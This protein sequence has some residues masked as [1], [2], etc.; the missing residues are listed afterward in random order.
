MG[1]YSRL[2]RNTA[3]IF[4]GTAGSKLMSL[5]MLPF[6][7]RWLTTADYGSTDLISTYAS[8][9]LGVV[10]FSIFDAIFIFPKNQSE[11]IQKKY[12]SSGM[13]FLFIGLAITALLSCIW[14]W[15]A[16]GIN[17][18][19]FITE[20]LWYI[21]GILGISYIQT[22]CQQ[23]LRAIDYMVVY[24]TTG[25]VTTI[26]TFG[27][28]FLLIPHGGVKGYVMAIICA[29]L[30][31]VIYSIVY[32]KLWRF[33]GVQY[34]SKES[35]TE[36]L[37]Y[38]IPLIPN[39]LMWFLINAL[40]RPVIEDYCGLSSVGL[41]AVAGR[42]PTLLN[43]VYLL[44]QQA[45]LISVL[46]ESSKP[47]YEEYYNRMLKIVVT[48]QIFFAAV[49]AFGGKWII[50]LFTTPDFYSAWKYISI[51]VIGVLFMNI[52]TFVGSNFAVLKKSKYYFY[53]TVWGGIASIVLNF[54]L[55]PFWGLWGACMAIVGSQA[56]V[57]ISRI[58][59]SSEFVKLTDA[60]F[61]IL[62]GIFICVCIICSL[63]LYDS[64]WMYISIILVMCYYC[65]INIRQIRLTKRLI[66]KYY[67]SRF[68][69]K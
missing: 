40:N 49:L 10:S 39:S 41:F 57:M 36:M 32:G 52:G 44:F 3:L 66:N 54:S 1:K 14:T 13:F 18:K 64:W 59:Y 58:K 42:F 34:I 68:K 48:V 67:E 29:N 23:F 6:Y 46:E 55:I 19:G 45:W 8:L 43:T 12:F 31:S 21:Y 50:E 69:N 5:L 27:F 65:F 11:I 15:I 28:S 60:R 4:V 62:N 7:T 33:I 24:S 56:V 30:I 37:K 47:D 17:Y 22:L 2:G 61:Y 51:L 16:E 35:L 25:I 63:L 26:C 9:M 20:Y 53:S 38:S